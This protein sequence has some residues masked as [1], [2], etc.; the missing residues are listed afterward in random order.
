M[1]V[2]LHPGQ[3]R[4]LSG[5]E[6][7]D[8][9]AE[10]KGEEEEDIVDGGNELE[11]EIARS[12]EGLAE[13][14]K[15]ENV[16]DDETVGIETGGDSQ[17]VAGIEDDPEEE[18]LEENPQTEGILEDTDQG[19]E[20][21]ADKARDG[22]EEV[23]ES[24]SDGESGEDLT[25]ECFYCFFVCLH[26]EVGIWRRADWLE[27][28]LQPV[29]L[30]SSHNTHAPPICNASVHKNQPVVLWRW[31]FLRLAFKC[32]INILV[33]GQNNYRRGGNTLNLNG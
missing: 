18:S 30:H 33:A 17:S 6:D 10:E 1:V 21:T 25:G 11:I 26:L 3:E 13:E 29:Y 28:G 5:A 16:S 7:K 9:D 8:E 14:A 22:K 19:L 4:K 31:I 23:I 2:R 15:L 24:E 32:S 12:E 20:D 27:D